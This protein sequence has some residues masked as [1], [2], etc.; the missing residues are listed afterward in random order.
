M[1]CVYFFHDR[2]YAL[3]VCIRDKD[4]TEEI[5]IGQTDELGYAAFIQLIEYIVQEQ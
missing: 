4:L 5:A 2:F 1:R 3:G